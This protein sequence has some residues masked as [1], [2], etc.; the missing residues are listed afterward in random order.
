MT[1]IQPFIIDI[2]PGILSD[3]QQRLQNTR[4]IQPLK[5]D[6]GWDYG[7]NVAYLKELADYWQHGY[8]WR[9]QEAKLNQLA[10]FK[11][12]IDGTGIHFIHERGKGPDP[13]PLILTHGWP[14]S[15]LRFQKIIP[16]LTDPAAYGAD[17]MDSFDVVVPSIP[18]FAFSDIPETS[19]AI[20]HVHDLWAKLMTKVLGYTKFGAH[21]GDWGALITEQLARS[22][23]GLLAGIHLTEVFFIHT[24][25]KPG[26]LSAAEQEYLAAMQQ[27]QQTQGA[28][29]MIQSTRP[30][31]LAA[32][33]HD[34]PVAL[35]AWLVEKFQ[36]WND[37]NGHLEQSF[38][39]DELLTNIMVYWVTGTINTSF[40]P[41]YDL[42]NAGPLTWMGEK[43]KEWMG[44]SKVPAAFALFPKDNSHPPREW[45]ERFFNVQR[46]TQ[47]ERGAH[48][49]AMEEPELL[50]RDIRAFFR[51]QRN[52]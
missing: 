44:S 47:L 33:L 27:F 40:L 18:G 20:F 31:T 4:W 10:Q 26:N 35:A 9:T 1:T 8:N 43:L 21:G 12:T 46:W 29:N 39:K 2:S 52:N 49:T 38:T 51:T 14:D 24:F 34:S 48:F 50:A 15:F 23:A 22:H 3:L 19:G 25:Q 5:K 11:A 41:Y 37:S 16:M 28:Y 17:P 7:V 6:A 32:G 36:A 42:M 30:Q 13:L 45:A